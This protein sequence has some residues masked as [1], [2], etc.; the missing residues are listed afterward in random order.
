MITTPMMPSTSDRDL[1]I[2]HR[3]Y[4]QLLPAGRLR[5]PPS[6]VLKKIEVQNWLF[7]KLFDG[8]GSNYLAP[9][10]YR[11]QVLK[12]L[13]RLIEDAFV[14]PEQD[15]RTDHRTA[16]WSLNRNRRYPTT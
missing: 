6:D 16:S 8:N 10:E 7:A 13:L 5:Y 12:K 14:D 4:L 1:E 3:Q 2:F 11:Q 9:P 15:V